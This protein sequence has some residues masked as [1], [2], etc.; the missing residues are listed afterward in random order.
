M[1]CSAR[2]SVDDA[3]QATSARYRQAPLSSFLMDIQDADLPNLQAFSQLCTR[4]SLT[5]EVKNA[6]AT[7]IG[8]TD[9]T[10][11]A[12]IANIAEADWK[13][14]ADRQ[15][16]IPVSGTADR[17]PTIVERSQI[18]LV[19]TTAQ[20]AVLRLPSIEQ[21]EKD[22][23]A[24]EAHAIAVAKASGPTVTPSSS[25]AIVPTRTF[26][27]ETVLD[28][29]DKKT[30]FKSLTADEVLACYRQYNKKLGSGSASAPP[31]TPHPDEEPTVDQLSGIKALTESG[32]PP[33]ADFAIFGPHANRLKKKIA[34]NGFVMARDGTFHLTELKG[35][36]NFTEWKDSY[37]IFKTCC[38]MLDIMSP[39]ALDN[40]ADHVSR[41]NMKYGESVW[42]ILYQTD[43]RARSEHVERIRRRGAEDEDKAK[44]TGGTSEYDPAK[45]WE[46]VYRHLV[47]D[48]KLWEEE[49]TSTALLVRSHID[50]LNEHLG[51]E[52][53]AEASRSSRPSGSRREPEGEP[54]PPP[55]GDGGGKRK[56]AERDISQGS[57][58]GP[59]GLYTT[60]RSGTQ[61]CRSYQDGSC[62][63]HA[64]VS[65]LPMCARNKRLAHQCAKCLGRHPANPAGGEAC[66]TRDSN[67]TIAIQQGK[68]TGKSRGKG[69][70]RR[71][72]E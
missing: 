11:A 10:P 14:I 68:G 3:L 61:L 59:D 34:M 28:Q 38:I 8:A 55:R 47:L 4:V 35:P 45:P 23:L 13:D 60:N 20:Y 39:A 50:R 16:K 57:R 7:V 46:Y 29:S 51:P 5:A 64:M 43:V 58:R 30:E 53:D 9:A 26:S 63:E 37:A 12:V 66:S 67:K 6:L 44:R 33:Y 70:R 69:N 62:K 71:P 15:V 27:A 41:L 21:R 18:G 40:Y 1:H 72:G 48:S 25:T 65:G 56:K 52:V 54:V 17:A 19:W 24:K 36:S 49:F 22:K 32:A 2:A 31:V 42:L